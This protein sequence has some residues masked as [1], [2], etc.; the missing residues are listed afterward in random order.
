MPVGMVI[1]RRVPACLARGDD[2]ERPV[3]CHTG[4]DFK[5]TGLNPAI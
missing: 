1:I 3:I 4:R 2:A 5:D